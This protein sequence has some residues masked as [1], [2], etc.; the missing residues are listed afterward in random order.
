M[1]TRDTTGVERVAHLAVEAVLHSCG[2]PLRVCGLGGDDPGPPCAV[3]AYGRAGLSSNGAELRNGR[4]APPCYGKSKTIIGE[5]R[6]TSGPR[7]TVEQRRGAVRQTSGAK[8]RAKCMFDDRSGRAKG[9]TSDPEDDSVS[10]PKDS[11]RIRKDV[12]TPFEDKPHHAE[13]CADLL[14]P[15]A[16]MLD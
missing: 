12:R 8:R 2:E 15:P 6:V 10:R 1:A 14:D 13:P 11:T 3:K 9:I 5:H 4:T 7:P 16:R